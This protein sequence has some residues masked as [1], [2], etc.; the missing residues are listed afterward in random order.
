MAMNYLDFKLLIGA[1]A[2]GIYNVTLLDSPGSGECHPAWRSRL[3]IRGSRAV[4]GR[5]NGRAA[6]MGAASLPVRQQTPMQP[7]RRF[8]PQPEVEAEMVA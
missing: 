5:W 2:S 6:K 7:L 4:S 1:G 3:P 8:H